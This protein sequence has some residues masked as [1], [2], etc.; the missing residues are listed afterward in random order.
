MDA[1]RHHRDDRDGRAASRWGAG[2]HPNGLARD[3]R[4]DEPRGATYTSEPLAEP[5]AIIGVPEAI[6][7]LTA[8]M[9]V[10]TCVVRL[11]EVTPDGASS[12]VATGVLNLTHRL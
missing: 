9:P 7:H 6:L 4:P 10:A 11:S 8:S 12:L 3:L 2:W 1:I 5:L